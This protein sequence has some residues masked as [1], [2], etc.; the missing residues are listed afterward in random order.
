MNKSTATA[1]QIAAYFADTHQQATSA[2]SSIKNLKIHS[3]SFLT[4]EALGA[5]NLAL[6]T[7]EQIQNTS[8]QTDAR[9]YFEAWEIENAE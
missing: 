8:T 2:V 4:A 7:L 6:A 9:K 5:L 3:T 1:M